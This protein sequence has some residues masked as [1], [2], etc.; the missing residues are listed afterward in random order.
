M[1]S[2]LTIQNAELE[3][4]V[5][6]NG[7]VGHGSICEYGSLGYSVDVDNH[8]YY[9]VDSIVEAKHLVVEFL[10]DDIRRSNPDTPFID[11][12]VKSCKAKICRID[13]HYAKKWAENPFSFESFGSAIDAIN[14]EK[15][16]AVKDYYERCIKQGCD[17]N[18]VDEAFECFGM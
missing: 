1:M 9:H 17:I 15:R 8:G 7:R 11:K 3:V 12:M 6:M 2:I 18:L 5:Y 16:F 13:K 10:K 14:A 4:W